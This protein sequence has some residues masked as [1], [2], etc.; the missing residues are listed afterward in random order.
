MSDNSK[1]TATEATELL[2]HFNKLTKEL[3]EA[4]DHDSNLFPEEYLLFKLAAYADQMRL[5][6]DVIRELLIAK[7]ICTE[8]EYMTARNRLTKAALD[9]YNNKIHTEMQRLDK[10][11]NENLINQQVI[12]NDD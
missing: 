2:G 10:L 3:V 6:T 9:H 4:I 8:T 1:M 11:R 12:N 7:G 5:E